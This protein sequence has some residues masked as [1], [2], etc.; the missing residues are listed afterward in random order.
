[1][2][3]EEGHAAVR[4]L[5][6]PLQRWTST[7]GSGCRRTTSPRSSART[8]TRTSTSTPSSGTA[9]CAPG[10]PCGGS[11]RRASTGMDG[12]MD[13]ITMSNL[14]G[15][16]PQRTFS[17]G[18]NTSEK[19]QIQTQIEVNLIL[20]MQITLMADS[21]CTPPRGRGRPSARWSG[22]SSSGAAGCAKTCK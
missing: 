9:R 2:T 7:T 19:L 10:S 22:R 13:G 12:W 21:C 18:A 16:V 17:Q 3:L 4:A 6:L 11:S 14:Y 15:Q 20:R 8:S 1:M 5:N